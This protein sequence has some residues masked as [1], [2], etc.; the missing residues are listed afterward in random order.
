MSASNHTSHTIHSGDIALKI[1]LALLP[2]ILALFFGFAAARIT[3]V[4]IDRRVDNLERQITECQQQ[5]ERDRKEAISHEEFIIYLN[6]L[7]KMLEEIQKDVRDVRAR[8][9]GR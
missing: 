2:S 7:T 5:V 4:A 9:L 8:R 3:N 6:G 1:A